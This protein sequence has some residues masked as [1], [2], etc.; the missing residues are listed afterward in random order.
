ME[1]QL[2]CRCYKHRDT[3]FRAGPTLAQFVTGIFQ[4]VSVCRVKRQHLRTLVIF[5]AAEN[6]QAAAGQVFGKLLG[7]SA[8]LPEGSVPQVTVFG[9]YR[10][11][12]WFSEPGVSCCS[13]V[14]RDLYK[15][16]GQTVERCAAPPS[17]AGPAELSRR[18]WW[19]PGPAVLP[20][21][22]KLWRRRAGRLWGLPGSALETLGHALG[23]QP[24]DQRVLRGAGAARPRPCSAARLVLPRYRHTAR[25]VHQV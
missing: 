17:R 18:S 16:A 9:F 20:V 23:S 21:C 13:L 25:G 22:L 7:G 2:T 12:S 6:S 8:W 19:S 10:S 11:W 14:E 1:V 3:I 24:W 15:A 4:S 5:L